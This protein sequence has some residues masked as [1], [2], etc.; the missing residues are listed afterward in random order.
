MTSRTCRVA[1]ALIIV[2]SIALVTT[3]HYTT[4]LEMTSFQVLC[5][6]EASRQD[7]Y[8]MEAISACWTMEDR[9]RPSS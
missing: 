7:V 8:I 6:Q 9:E 5:S 4:P 3:A 1:R 2:G